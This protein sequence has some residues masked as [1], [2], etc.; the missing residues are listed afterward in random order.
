MAQTAGATFDFGTIAERYD[1][2]YETPDGAMYDRLE[3]R[4]VGRLLPRD[5]RG[6]ELLDVGCGTGH[7]ARFFT[8][9]GFRVTGID[10]SSAMVRVA[11]EKAVPGASFAIADAHAMPFASGRFEVA[12]AI[13]TLEFVRDPQAA[14]REMAR[15]ARRP[16]GI[17]LVGALNALAPI[18]R[19]RKASGKPTYKEARFFSPRDLQALLASYGQARVAS[20][21]LVPSARWLLPLAPLADAVGRLL[22][23]PY[24]A[25]VVGRAE[26]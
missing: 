17:M 3:K 18:N 22:R 11:R 15:C 12:V 8:E 26:L 10:V 25:W 19:R 20:A 21:A 23:L 7:W 6:K 4:A 2:W 16:G 14:L 1:Q 5:G 24:G 9:R 13:A